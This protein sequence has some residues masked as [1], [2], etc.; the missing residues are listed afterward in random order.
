VVYQLNE[1]SLWESKKEDQKSEILSSSKSS[2]GV[3]SDLPF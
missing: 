3:Q 1:G 2:D